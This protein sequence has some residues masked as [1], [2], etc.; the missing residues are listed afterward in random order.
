MASLAEILLGKDNPVTQWTG[1]NSNLLTG[2]GTSL[3]S[4]G[5]NFQPAQ[6]GATLDRQAAAQKDADAKLAAT[7]NAT[8]TWLAQKYP[9]LA[10]AVDAGLPVSDA[11][12]EA[13]KRQQPG[14]GQGEAVKGMEIN[15]KLVNPITGEVIGD[16]GS[17][18]AG[19]TAPAGYRVAQDGTN[20]E[21]IPGGPAD[22][23]RKATGPMDATT[24][25]EL[26]EADDAAKAGEYVLSALDE[27]ISLNDKAYDG[28][29]ADVRGDT[30]ALWGDKSGVAT[31]RMK[32]VTTELALSQLKTIFGSMPTE[33][34]RKILLE[35]QGSVNQARPVRAGILKRAREL[36][37]RRIAD[38][39]AKAGG[40]RSGQYF[41]DGYGGG[42]DADVEGILSGLG[43]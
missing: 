30:A 34:E 27:A 3:L 19:P 21:F 26:F 43:I 28:P 18:A 5:M 7:S 25:R 20:L 35:L 9:D 33:G 14:Y 40:L 37:E 31:A 12:Q 13:F 8:K 23:A 22:P 2:L 15:G 11:W 38:A 41:Q 24:K 32:N 1:R 39:K 16:Y 4:D 10:Q 17:P 42:G 6:V 29:T 36:A